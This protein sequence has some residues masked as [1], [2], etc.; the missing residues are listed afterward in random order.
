VVVFRGNADFSETEFLK[1][2]TIE[3]NIMLKS[4]GLAK[5]TSGFLGRIFGWL[6]IHPNVVTI[7]AVLFSIAGFVSFLYSDFLVGFAFFVLAFLL[8]AVD[9]AIA[10]AKGLVSKKGAFLDGIS[11]RVVEFFLVLALFVFAKGNLEMQLVLLAILFFGTC[12]TSFVKAYS[13]HAGLLDN[14]AAKK[15]PGLLERAERSV[16]LLL[17]PV[18]LI[19][20]FESWILPLLGLVALL[21]FITFAQRIWYVISR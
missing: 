8:D 16:L 4:S 17:G 3:S 7:I 21:S 12:M 13:E 10:R 1:A 2:K 18:L 19:L 9:G 20:G 14:E 15:M 6:P 5:G 11:D